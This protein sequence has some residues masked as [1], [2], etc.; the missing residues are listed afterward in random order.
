MI[1]PL[2]SSTVV[3][4]T[5]A[6]AALKKRGKSEEAVLDVAGMSADAHQLH[7]KDCGIQMSQGCLET[8]VSVLAA[9]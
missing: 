7:S 6:R 1:I 4:L 2:A 8:T 3:G 5:L 9:H